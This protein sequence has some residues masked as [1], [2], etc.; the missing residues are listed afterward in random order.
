MNQGICRLCDQKKDL[1]KAHII[2][3][4]I[5]KYVSYHKHPQ[6]DGLKVMKRNK[7][8]RIPKIPTMGYY[9]N[10]ILCSSCDNELGKFDDYFANFLKTNFSKFRKSH[11]NRYFY[12]NFPLDYKKL[13]LFAISCLWRASLTQNKCFEEVNLGSFEETAKNLIKSESIQG[14][15]CFEIYIQYFHDVVSTS[16]LPHITMPFT[17][18]KLSYFGP[19]LN[20]YV[21]SF[22]NVRLFIKVDSQSIPSK[23][24]K[25]LIDDNNKIM[26]EHTYKS[27]D[28]NQHF[29]NPMKEIKALFSII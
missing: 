29:N 28:D 10:N 24:K 5:I 3:K 4:C 18:K 1:I 2:A 8:D 21:T 26:L 22:G 19:T 23:W 25:L 16:S 27:K 13:K 6:E 15:D 20:F 9:D 14:S 17:R 7:F 11:A 12:Q